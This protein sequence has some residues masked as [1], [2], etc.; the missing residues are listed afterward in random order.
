[1]L[2][3]SLFIALGALTALAGCAKPGPPP[4]GP[5]D[6]DPPWVVSTEPLDGAVD[7]AVDS[8]VFVLFSEEMDRASVERAVDITPETVLRRAGWRGP[9]LEIRTAEELSDSTTYVVTL[10]DGMRDYHGV[11]TDTT[12]TLAFSTG[13]AIDDCAVT[14]TV[15]A[16]GEPAVGATV[17]VCSTSPKPDSLGVIGRC[18]SSAMTA[19]GGSF[20]IG[21][22]NPSRSPYSLVAFLD[23]DGDGAYSPW[24]E[25][26]TVT[27]DAVTFAA[28][29][30]TMRGVALALEP[31]TDAS[32]SPVTEPTTAEPP[33]GEPTSIDD[34]TPQPGDDPGLDP[35]PAEPE[36]QE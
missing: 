6:E 23:S 3:C 33:A 19:A 30:D 20:D 27:F 8:G 9:R 15:T 32:T 4:G 31:P 22:L 28:P 17:W 24:E 1:M 2:R 21:Y 26:G 14:G 34:V 16:D 5:I 12:V 18:G 10:G 25:A 11:A 7:V 13:G 35:P 29:G 36:E